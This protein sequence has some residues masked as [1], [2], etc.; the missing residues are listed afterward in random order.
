MAPKRQHQVRERIAAFP[1]FPDDALID[2]HT[3][4][5]LLSC[6]VETIKRRVRAKQFPPPLV[7]TPNT[8]R[9]RAG[10]IR[11]VLAHLAAADQA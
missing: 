8:H 2:P 3:V 7:L 11:R 4:A 1:T 5:G 6:S 10:D 9:W